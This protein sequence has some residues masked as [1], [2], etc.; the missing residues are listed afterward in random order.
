MAKKVNVPNLDDI[1]FN[2]ALELAKALSGRSYEELSWETQIP[3]STLQRMFTDNDY[4]P[5]APNIPKICD[6]LGNNLLIEWFVAQVDG[7]LIVNEVDLTTVSV[8]V[9]V[10]QSTK[11]Q[12]DILSKYSQAMNDGKLDIAE[13]EMLQIEVEESIIVNEKLLMKIRRDKANIKELQND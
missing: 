4:H 5:G 13:L 6:A 8:G 3:K 7:H 2:Q 11:E 12:S 9:L 10:S 1:S